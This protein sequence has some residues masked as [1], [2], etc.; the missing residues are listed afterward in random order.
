MALTKKEK[1]VI[2]ESR[3]YEMTALNG[4][5]YKGFINKA[6]DAKGNMVSFTSPTPLKV[7]DAGGYDESLAVELQLY[8]RTY[9]DQVK[10]STDKHDA[11]A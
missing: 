2:F 1:F 9:K 10:W 5:S 7:T 6:F 4:K 11:V 3:T 8:G